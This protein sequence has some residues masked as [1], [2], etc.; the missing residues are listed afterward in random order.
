MIKTISKTLIAAALLSAV[1][2]Q[3]ADTIVF[4]DA[5]GKVINST[6]VVNGTS[7]SADWY[8]PTATA[9]GIVSVQHG[10]SRNCGHQRDSTKRFMASGL[11]ALCINA[12]MSGG[13]EALADQLA[14]KLI[15]PSLLTPDGRAVPYKIVVGGHS[16][17]G[18]FGSRLGWKLNSIAPDRLAGAVFFDPVAGNTTSFMT[19]MTTISQNGLRPVYAVTANSNICNSSNNAYAALKQVRTNAIANGRD[20]FVG[21]QLT[22]SS[23]HVDSEG[24]NTNATGYLACFQGAPKTYNT[25][26]LRDLSSQWALDIVNNVKTA[27]MYPNG[28]YVNNLISISRGKLIQ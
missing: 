21:M 25:G 19:N 23:T 3:A 15:D 28:S 5:T 26:Y 1:T 11:M 24:N 16:A 6:L 14:A 22:S 13:N 10:F 7:Y 4:Q 9:N 27:A 8:L 2:A 20:G 18:H 12:S 17:G